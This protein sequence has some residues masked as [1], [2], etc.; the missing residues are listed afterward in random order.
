M[1][2]SSWQGAKRYIA[3]EYQ[4]RITRK[5][6]K[7]LEIQI[8]I[9]RKL[10]KILENQIRIYSKL[11]KIQKSINIVRISSEVISSACPDGFFIELQATVQVSLGKICPGN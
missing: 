4:I 5:L 2:R 11:S 3:L 1:C 6:S 10:S 9:Y 7:I 8:R